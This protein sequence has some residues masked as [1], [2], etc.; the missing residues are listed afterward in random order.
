MSNFSCSVLLGLTATA[1]VWS[2]LA[3]QAATFDYNRIKNISARPIAS[4]D[5][6]SFFGDLKR[7]EGYVGIS[8]LDPN[9]PDAG[10]VG[11]RPNTGNADYYALGRSRSPELSGA[12]RA[13]SLENVK[14]FSNF[15]NYLNDNNI[16]LGSI[17]FSFGPKSDRP[18]TK[19]WNLGKDKLGQD[20]YGSPDSTIE[21]IVYQA[22][23]DDVEIFLAY[24]NTKII[25]FGYTP[26]YLISVNEDP[27]TNLFNNMNIHLTEPISVSKVAG[28]DPFAS[29]L[30]NA[31][32]QD[33]SAAGGSVQFVAQYE[34]DASDISFSES[35]G[36]GMFN[37]SFPV[38]LR[39]VNNTSV[40]EPNSILG[41]LAFGS[42]GVILRRSQKKN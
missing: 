40:P 20:W 10:H 42:L 32:L 27:T 38:E 12:T 1:L 9:A 37:L 19:T 21:E 25:N 23:P 18:F 2:P 22:N 14:G 41:L 33:V 31:F 36:Y 15:F 39:A 26:L 7:N 34:P 17:G 8:N 24:G 11:F 30:A 28:L 3:T 6:L 4:N 13:A 16:S 5:V 35:Q 29:G